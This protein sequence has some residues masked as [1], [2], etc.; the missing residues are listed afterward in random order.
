VRNKRQ[1]YLLFVSTAIFSISVAVL[2]SQAITGALTNDKAAQ[3]KLFR[4]YVNGVR[5]IRENYVEERDYEPLTTAAIQGM[6]RALDPHSNFY[7]RK[8]FDDMRM[9]QRSQYYGI[10]AS[11][12]ERYR[13]VYI[14][15]P[16]KDTPAARAGLRYGDQIVAVDGK[17]TEGWSSDRVRDTLRGE[18]GTEVKV[19]LRRAGLDEPLTVEIERGAVDLPS[20]SSFYIAH[21]GIGYIALS[22]G[23]HSTTSDELIAAIANL[24][25]QGMTSLVLDLR[26]NPGGFLD[27]AIR[28]ADKFLHRGQTIVSV[29]G[30]DGRPGD[31]DWPA[32]SG[33][34]ETF[35]LVVLIDDGSAS[36]S[37]IVAG[38]IQDHDRGL[39]IGEPSFGKGLVQTIYPLTGGVGLTLTTARYYTPSGRLIQRDYSNGSSYEYHFRRNSNG[40]QSG[41]PGPRND[42]RRTDTGR[43]VYGGGGIEPDIKVVPKPVTGI[44][45]A[46]WRTGLFAF[47]R[48]LMAGNIAAAPHFKRNGPEFNHQP[49]PGE[50]LITDEIMKAY[51]EFMTHYLAKNPE[52]GLTIAMVDENMQWER[53]KIR[54]EV[55]SAAYGQDVQRRIM[56]DQ[57]EQLQR[58]ILE[59][60]Q[61]AQ[62]A[63]RARRMNRTSKK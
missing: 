51:R 30:R 36:A 55:L 3:D 29:R 41:A 20:I 11:I 7:D 17:S 9:E 24:K 26:Q 43:L 8:A 33:M 45:G 34:P 15:E 54:E 56:A 27:Q 52:I 53:D 18:L 12:Q 19:A 37:E 63:E 39:I 4:D 46:I 58:A 22:R 23:F 6:L 16:F 31:K 2:S 59:M 21:P 49:V 61:A 44:Q 13:G 60:P 1:R 25:A 47:V 32:E 14:I 5:V 42:Q 62:L 40:P 10:G 35:P 38:A 28:V 57:D 48:E 50:F